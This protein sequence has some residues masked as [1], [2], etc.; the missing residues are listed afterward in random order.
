M[1]LEEEASHY[2]VRVH[3][4]RV[5]DAFI[6]FDPEQA[7]EADAELT[8]TKQRCAIC[9]VQAIRPAVSSGLPITLLQGFGKGDKADQV[10]R[11]ATALGAARIVIVE[12][13]RSVVRLSGAREERS[14]QRLAR[15]R[16]IAVEAARQCG[17]SELPEIH[18]PMSL[19]A[20]LSAY[21]GEHDVGFCC[22]VAAE[23][24][25]VDAVSEWKPQ[26]RTVVLVGPEG[27]LSEQELRSA[28]Q[29]GLTRVRLGPFT[30]RTE[31]AAT[32]VLGALFLHGRS[33]AV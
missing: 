19:G 33:V 29:A 14:E 24:R 5:G 31:T 22:D 23:Q 26:L 25:L 7:T 12:T 8:H 1:T 2:L 32:V 17:R 28:E 11:D 15:W 20:A 27:G 16:K 21:G 3:R 30:L 6:A 9:R 18:G 13:E 10:V 4:L